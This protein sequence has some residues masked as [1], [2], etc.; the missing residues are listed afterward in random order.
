MNGVYPTL[1][2]GAAAPPLRALESLPRGGE[3]YR[4]VARADVL[5][6]NAAT[7]Y[8]LEDVRGYEP[9]VL[10]D[11]AE[12]PRRARPIRF[13]PSRPRRASRSPMAP[14]AR[15]TARSVDGSATASSG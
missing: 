14:W 9:F 2:A 12:T 13:A 1:P 8:G 3:P 15:S 11:L 7:L 10:A 5:R 4:I 6:P